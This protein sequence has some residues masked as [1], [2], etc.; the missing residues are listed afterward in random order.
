MPLLKTGNSK[1]AIP[2]L[3]VALYCVPFT[4]TVTLPVAFS[5]NVIVMFTE[6]LGAT[7]W[8][9]PILVDILYTLKLVSFSADAL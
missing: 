9:S 7:T 3:T 2:F 1:V 4:T 8:L 6:L 5:F